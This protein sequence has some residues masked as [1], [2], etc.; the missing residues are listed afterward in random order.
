VRPASLARFLSL[1]PLARRSI[2]AAGAFALAGVVVSFM[3]AGACS[4]EHFPVLYGPYD[5]GSY[6]DGGPL[7]SNPP[8][9]IQ[10]S[11]RVDSASSPVVFDPARGGVWTANG[12]VGS[13]SY[14]DVDSFKLVQEIP[15]GV[16]VRSVALSPDGHWLAAVDRGGA[17]VALIDADAR[18]LIR[19]IPIGA[20]P[21]AAVW[22]AA[23]PRWLYV[24]V[25]DTDS[26][27]VIDRTLGVLSTTIPVGR[28]PSGVAV[29]R[30]RR[31][32]YVTHRI[33]GK[34]TIVPLTVDADAGPAPA[35]DGGDTDAGA[36][37]PLQ[38]PA[39]VPLAFEVGDGTQTT[40]HGTPFGLESLSWTAGGDVAW[41]PHELIASTHPF[42][43]QT[44]LFPT[45]SVVDLAQRAE[46]QTDPNDPN[47]AIAGRKNLFAA[48]TLFDATNNEIVLSQPC[49]AA[50]HPNGVTGYVLACA[51]EDLITFDLI[52]GI[53]VDI[54]R[55]LPGDHPVGLALDTAG[56]RA[57][58]LADE[59]QDPASPAAPL[60]SKSLHVLDVG[61]G[62]L[63]AHVKVIG[64]PIALV[65]KDPIPADMRAGL[66]A[67]F[68]ANSSKGTLAT[69]G[70]NWMSCGGCHLD[71]FVSTNEAFFEDLKAGVD[72]TVDARIGH[73]G[74]IDFFSTAPPA[75]AANDPPFNP[76]DVLTAFT[77]MGG[78][79]P[80]RTG[81][82]RAG[83]IDPSAPTGDATT[84]ASQIAT[85]ITRDLPL[86]PTWLLPGTAKPN[87]AYDGAWC[88]T[89]H[90]KEL[91]AWQ[92][93]VHA[94]AAVDPMVHFCAGVEAA[95]N[96]AQYPRLCAGCH[97][98]V[99]ARLGDT[100]LA[101]GRG[102]TCLGCH[103]G[104]RLIQAGGNA[105][106]EVSTSDWTQDHAARAA[107]TLVTL[108]DPKFCGTCHEQFVP[109]IGIEAIDTLHE[110]QASTYAGAA[111]IVD[112]GAVPLVED[113]GSVTRCVDCH[114]AKDTTGVADHSMVGGNV[115]VATAITNDPVMAAAEMANVSLAINLTAARTGDAV[116]VTV[117]NRASG[118]AFPTG[119][120]DIRE[121]WVELQAVDGQKNVIAHYG[122]PAVDGTIPLD[123]AR[124][125]MDIASADGGVLYLH[126]LSQTTRIPFA[127]FVPPHGSVDVTLTAPDSLPSPAVELDA[128][129]Y[130]RNVRTP[131]FRA[132]TG[133]ASAT[134]PTIE[135]AR[136]QVQ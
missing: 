27:A 53:A 108:R 88:G 124:F 29:S 103:D 50:F 38:S 71:G 92:K 110:Y 109:G 83:A 25:E 84:L 101:S 122:G 85:V 17:S 125:G 20:H 80:D 81:A 56:A 94:H 51:S 121:P 9:I 43:F 76:H 30:K 39:D 67:F 118:H 134:A 123:A 131:Y 99:S 75:N 21:R 132:A 54:L 1:A 86:G 11:A 120:T 70:N 62:S 79:A 2:R 98:P 28:L 68:R 136:V 96:G 113:A 93:S 89:C 7:E 37:T 97:D 5:A 49:A 33:D 18:A 58:V 119:V 24:A 42:Q 40:P 35:D 45:V 115:Y 116:T 4:A 12:D 47:G 66:R 105:D 128:V 114:A 16:D 126:Q 135:V 111:P 8:A 106:L 31:E 15:V 6:A 104:E 26:V 60:H 133:D 87:A 44:T 23:N 78:L 14:A 77:E 72:V 36:F 91:A 64:A 61:G 34:V 102:V 3:L 10:P 57:F 19:T 130:Y 59:T 107:A 52:Q 73:T 22:D 100:T 82:Q 46:V 48:M 32:L 63:I 41:L 127:R 13:V 74:L 129:L 95:N 112:A 65:A 117:T 55:G 69:T 90:A